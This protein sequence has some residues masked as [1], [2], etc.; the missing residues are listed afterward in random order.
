MQ[1]VLYVKAHTYNTHINTT[2]NKEQLTWCACACQGSSSA[3]LRGDDTK[4]IGRPHPRRPSDQSSLS[5]S[6]HPLRPASL[7]APTPCSLTPHR[8]LR[9]PYQV[10]RAP[11]ARCLCVTLRYVLLLLCM[12]C[13]CGVRDSTHLLGGG[14]GIKSR[15]EKHFASGDVRA[16]DRRTVLLEHWRRNTKLKLQNGTYRHQYCQ[17]GPHLSLVRRSAAAATTCSMLVRYIYEYVVD[18]TDKWRFRTLFYVESYALI[19]RVIRSN[20][21]IYVDVTAPTPLLCDILSSCLYR[22]CISQ[23]QHRR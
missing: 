4:F 8:H 3:A 9:T 1:S 16:L 18:L 5:E 23:P 7:A 2:S 10:W 17:F 19:H 22:I 20:I 6:D 14:A 13:M 12:T 21:I 15:R 11:V